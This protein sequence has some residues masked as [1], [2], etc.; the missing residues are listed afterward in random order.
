[1]TTTRQVV[2]FSDTDTWAGGHLARPRIQVP[3]Y[4]SGAQFSNNS[5][6]STAVTVHA[7]LF[8]SGKATDLGTLGGHSRYASGFNDS[9][10]IV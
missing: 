1:L 10:T 6:G 8:E 9:G 5:A 4:F 3:N 2:G 7:A